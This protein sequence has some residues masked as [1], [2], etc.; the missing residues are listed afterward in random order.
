M[1]L[2]A[3]V[4]LTMVALLTAPAVAQDGPTTS[5]ADS[6]SGQEDHRQV[7]RALAQA[8]DVNCALVVAWNK[9]VN[10]IAFAEDEFRTFKGVRAHAMIH[11]AMHD[12]L[13]AIVPLYRQYAF[14]GH[15]PSANPLSR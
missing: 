4:V 8:G 10:D 9:M 15:K 7:E 5:L 11:I 14:H 3:M 2:H 6:S 13:N 1:R 12:A